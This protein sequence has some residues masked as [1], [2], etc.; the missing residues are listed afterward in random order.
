MAE[1]SANDRGL[2][3]LSQSLGRLEVSEAALSFRCVAA[4]PRARAQRLRAQQLFAWGAPSEA[5]EMMVTLLITRPCRSQRP[6]QNNRNV[7]ALIVTAQAQHLR[8]LRRL[9]LVSGAARDG[10]S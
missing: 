10:G 9:Q 5:E 2:E 3:E 1:A 4:A 8:H 6:N 7:E